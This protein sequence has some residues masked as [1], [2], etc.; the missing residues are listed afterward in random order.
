MPYMPCHQWVE[1]GSDVLT[2]RQQL[3]LDYIN[4]RIRETGFPPSMRMI[5]RRF[6]IK[7]T[8]GV[9]DHLRAL[10]RKGYLQTTSRGIGK[11]SRMYIPSGKTHAGEIAPACASAREVRCDTNGRHFGV[12]AVA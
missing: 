8:N 1:A 7:S 3:I 2:E 5:G 10:E 6:Q 12:C 11:N 9:S 4:E